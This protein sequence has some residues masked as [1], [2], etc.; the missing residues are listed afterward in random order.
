MYKDK[1]CLPG[2]CFNRPSAKS[3]G[4]VE[5]PASGFD[6]EHYKK[7]NGHKVLTRNSSYPRD[8]GKALKEKKK[9][10]KRRN[11]ELAVKEGTESDDTTSVSALTMGGEDSQDLLDNSVSGQKTRSVMT[12]QIFSQGPLKISR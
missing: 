8:P 11:Q 6:R 12:P 3:Q 1:I 9:K 4:E 7:L 5:F 2:K 10:G